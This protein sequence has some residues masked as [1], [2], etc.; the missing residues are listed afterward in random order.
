MSQRIHPRDSILLCCSP[1]QQ[2]R[3]LEPGLSALI[4]AC[5]HT[6]PMFT[7]RN[8]SPSHCCLCASIET[9][10]RWSRAIAA[11]LSKDHRRIGFLCAAYR[12]PSHSC[13]VV[14]CTS[15][16][17]T[18][19]SSVPTHASPIGEITVRM[20]RA[21]IVAGRRR[22]TMLTTS[23]HV[24]RAERTFARRRLPGR[25]RCPSSLHCSS[26]G[27]PQEQEGLRLSLDAACP[28]LR[29]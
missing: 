1:G 23:S 3:L 8:T 22:A 13:S 11:S 17:C 14:S 16:F 28:G 29:P 12:S 24:R 21:E 5:P 27:V 19:W 6:A 26:Q 9:C 20:C 18:N 4:P 7:S 25:L 15:S 10:S 2:E